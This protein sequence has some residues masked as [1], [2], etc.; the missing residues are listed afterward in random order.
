MAGETRVNP[1]SASGSLNMKFVERS[2]LKC[3]LSVVDGV[4]RYAASG[5]GAVFSPP[6]RLKVISEGRVFHFPPA[7]ASR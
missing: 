1:G 3:E 7:A 6:E 5:K 2:A 4:Q